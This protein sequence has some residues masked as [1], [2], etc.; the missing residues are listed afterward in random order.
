MDNGLLYL[1]LDTSALDKLAEDVRTRAEPVLSRAVADLTAMGH[2]EIIR[3]ATSELHM[4]RERYIKALS[5]SKVSDDTWII[6]LGEDAA[7]IDDGL[8]EN[9]DMLKGLLNSPKAKVAKDGSRYVV[10]PMSHGSGPN[11]LS[12]QHG[13]AQS[14]L[15]Q[16]V[17]DELKSRKIPFARV[18]RDIN[19]G[20]AKL[21]K[22]HDFSVS[23][24]NHPRKLWEG[25]GQGVG[26]IGE[27]RQ[28]H[29]GDAFLDRIAVYQK[30][31]RN[32]KSGKSKT[33]RQ[34]LTFRTASS[35]QPNTMWRHPGT[36]GLFAFERAYDYLINQWT[37]MMPGLLAEITGE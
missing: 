25:P 30:T 36:K 14:D 32:P 2:A 15:K 31:V 1:E 4:R 33:V 34:I 19:T 28:G 3:I 9:T 37:E 26:P 8:P 29:T 12:S 24:K 23:D 13:K 7:W 21:G 6:T 22:L 11:E 18:E 17:Q 35:K 27:V 16:A 20:N 5:F 10:V